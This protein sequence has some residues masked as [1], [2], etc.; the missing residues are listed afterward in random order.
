MGIASSDKFDLECFLGQS[1]FRV[2]GLV[3]KGDDL[4]ASP[5]YFKFIQGNFGF[6]VGNLACTAGRASLV[7][8]DARNHSY[9]VIKINAEPFEA[10]ILRAE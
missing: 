5:S 4:Q 1:A 3:P 6:H 9:S 10:N 8:E 2:S 7:F